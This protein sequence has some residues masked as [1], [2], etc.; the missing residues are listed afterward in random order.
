MGPARP[1]LVTLEVHKAWIEVAAPYSL[2]AIVASSDRIIQDALAAT[3]AEQG[4]KAVDALRP[5]V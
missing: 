4:N 5:H 2:F 3:L 1:V